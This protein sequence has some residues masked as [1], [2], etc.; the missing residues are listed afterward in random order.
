MNGKQRAYLRKL[1]NDA[2]T[3]FQ[4]GK[5]GITEVLCT[6]FDLALA[7]RELVKAK[8]LE[9][10]G[11]TAREAAEEIAAACGAEVITCIGFKFVLYKKNAKEPK[12]KLPL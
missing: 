12:I 9:T 7:A 2:E 5:G 6:E 8:V 10:A 11:L 4:I 3:I 1:A